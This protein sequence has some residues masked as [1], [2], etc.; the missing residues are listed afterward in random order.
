MNRLKEKYLKEIRGKLREEFNLN[1]DLAVPKINKV[2]INIGSSEIKDSEDVLKRIKENL[3]VLSGQQ[4]V[5]TKAR[6]S[7][8]A[9]KLT[10]GAPIGLMVTLRKEK[11]V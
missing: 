4:P 2:V 3:A 8:S 10:E 9:F 11:N 6:K 1:S 7:I 5:V